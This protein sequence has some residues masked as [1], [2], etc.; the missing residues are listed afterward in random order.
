MSAAEEQNVMQVCKYNPLHNFPD[1]EKE[2]HEASCKRIF[3]TE[4]FLARL[5]VITG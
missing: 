4:R 2:F 5:D 3:Y 1:V